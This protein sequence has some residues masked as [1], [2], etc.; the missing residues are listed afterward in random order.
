MRSVSRLSRLLLT[1]LLFAGLLTACDSSPTGV[2]D[3]D[4][5]ADVELSTQNLTFIAGQNPS[6]TITLTY[7]GL[8]SAPEL[9]ATG[10]LQLAQVAETGS[11]GDGGSME[12][13]V[14]YDGF[15]SGNTADGEIT[16][17]SARDGEE[18][19][20]T[21]PVQVNNPVSVFSDFSPQYAGVADYEDDQRNV[22]TAN[23][24]SATVQ[25]SV[26]AANS[27]G[28]NAL[29]VTSPT[30][31]TVTIER[32]A[33]L[34]GTEVFTFL[35]KPD[36]SQDFTLTLTFT[37]DVNGQ[38]ESFD[39]EVPVTAGSDWQE[40][41][42]AARQLFS[43]FD[44]VG[45]QDG[46]DGMLQ[47]IS[48]TT[49]A[50]VTYH[51]DEMGFGTTSGTTYEI[52]DF[53]QTTNAYGSFSAIAIS[54]T[55][56]VGPGS[57]GPTARSMSWTTGDN[58][59]GYNYDSLYFDASSGGEVKILIGEV[60]KTFD[61]WVFVETNGDTGGYGFNSGTTVEVAAGGDFR[62]VSVPLSSLG[63]DPSVLATDGIRNVGFEL[64]RTAS[65]ESDDP[66]S[67]IIDNIRLQNQ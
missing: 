5:Q 50:D 65:D 44:P 19:T 7:Q 28:D 49:D 20:K 58:F 52:A 45:A 11:P 1:L 51:L 12:Y 61:L 26:V 64:R 35:L 38:E 29:E 60:S 55:S 9:S 33:N 43:D 57:D 10:S 36:A 31:G 16:V 13:S 54:D 17:T 6:P 34:P 46:G 56:A 23:G 32:E 25:Q 18:I 24:A 15:V 8:D 66:I 4:I 67:L 53:E 42:I 21:L 30:D 59:F 63:S 37:E 22:V 41:V 39:L 62:T 2:D 40:Y 47:S 14:S 27:N 48:F 3:F